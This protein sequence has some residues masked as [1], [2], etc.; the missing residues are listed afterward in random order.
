MQERSAG[1]TYVDRS[2]KMNLEEYTYYRTGTTKIQVV[3]RNMFVKPFFSSSLKDF[4]KYWNPTWGY[5]LLFYGYKPLKNI[6]PAWLAL[7]MTF[8]ISGLVH[9]L[10]YILPMMLQE[11]R[12]V[13]PLITVWFVIIAVGI[14]VTEYRGIDFKY[15]NVKLR[16]LFHLAYLVA[17]FILTRY[18][19]L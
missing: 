12:F 14:L 15:I 3:V 11:V 5:Y 19:D 1:R 6:F 16:P 7:M 10:I 13:F 4:W 9:D 17:T 2:K 8:F 18:I